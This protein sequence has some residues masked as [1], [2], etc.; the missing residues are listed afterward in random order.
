MA[1]PGVF[2]R[3]SSATV[4]RGRRRGAQPPAQ[5]A[6]AWAPTSHLPDVTAPLKTAEE[7]TSLFGVVNQPVAQ[8]HTAHREAGACDIL[9]EPSHDGRGTFD[10]SAADDWIA[11]GVAAA[12]SVRGRLDSLVAALERP[13]VVRKGPGPPVARWIDA[14][15]TPGLDSAH[16][17]LARRRLGLACRSRSTR[18]TSPTRGPPAPP[19][20]S[21]RWGTYGFSASDTGAH[22]ILQAGAGGG[23]TLGIGA[24]YEG[25][26]KASLLFTATLQDRLEPD[27]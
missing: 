6:L 12:D 19:A 15:A 8:Q 3:S 25:A 11:R 21:T 1:I 14:L 2:S 5:D 17:R 10:F 18:A 24:R 20:I 16:A 22:L 27:R 13:R 4:V 9:I 26:Y 23:S 7:L